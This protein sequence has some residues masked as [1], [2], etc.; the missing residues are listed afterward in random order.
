MDSTVSIF[1]LKMEDGIT[2]FLL[3]S[4]LLLTCG[5]SREDDAVCVRPIL[6][7]NIELASNQTHFSPGEAIVLSCKQG[8]TPVS[9]PRRI[10]CIVD[11]TWTRTRYMC[12]SKL[13]PY[14]D[15]PANG[16]QYYE[17]TVYLS[18]INYTCHEGYT[19][20]GSR[21]A[22]C[23]AN[24]TW[25]TPTPECKAVSCGLAP[26][27]K[28]GM[29]IYDRTVRGDK[30][31]FGIGGTYRCLPPYALFG[32][33]RAECTIRGTW[34]KTPEC[35]VVTCPPPDN[36][37]KGYMS[38]GDRRDF[39]FMETVKYG[40]NDDYVLDGN[41]EIVCQQNGNWSE[42][43]SCKASCPIESEKAK[44][45]YRGKKTWTSDL[46]NKV[47]LHKEIVSFYCKDTVRNC[48]YTVPTQCLDGVLKL[49]E[50]F[51]ELSKFE[52]NLNSTEIQQ[53]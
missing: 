22:V 31:Y 41:M 20:K 7:G 45:E 32:N 12:K 51:E 18:T 10:V 28:F 21:T 42:K 9:G 19:L 33:P 39:D 35:R 49:P 40:C 44:I 43:P 2:F 30:T 6:D 48:T 47:I 52:Y 50:C 26:I 29:I 38:N 8:Y 16:E 14:P 37:E 5:L 13:C 1:Q 34:T 53:C 15:P 27:P 36:I 46:Q 4:V 17:D 3:S 24:G 11:G 25:S 23:Q